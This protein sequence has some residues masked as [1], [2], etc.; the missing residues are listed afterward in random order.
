MGCCLLASGAIAD[1]VGDRLV[2]LI[3][4]FLLTVFVLANGFVT[5]G[6]QL[7][8]CRAIQGVGISMCMPTAVSIMTRSLRAG[9]L[10]N[11]AFSS[12]GVAQPIG[13]SLGLVLQGWIEVA[14]GNWR[15]GYYVCTGVFIFLFICNLLC[16]PANPPREDSSFTALVSTIDWIGLFIASAAFGLIS[17]TCT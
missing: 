15:F 13:F 11:I 6:M 12:L 8:I 2:N 3:G 16:L 10:R 7:V 4:S 1:H 9:R 14:T 5:N 17:Y